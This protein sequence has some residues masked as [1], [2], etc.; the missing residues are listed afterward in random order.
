MRE[1][2]KSVNFQIEES[3][4]CAIEKVRVKDES[5]TK[6]FKE[7]LELLIKVRE[8]QLELT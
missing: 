2:K 3:L 6:F 8:K 1:Y 5:R 4:D 7:A